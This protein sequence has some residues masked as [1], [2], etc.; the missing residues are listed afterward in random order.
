MREWR[1]AYLE[2]GVPG[3]EDVNLLLGSVDHDGDQILEV[4]LDRASLLELDETSTEGVSGKSVELQSLARLSSTRLSLRRTHKPEPEVGCDLVVPASSGVQLSSN[5]LADNLGQSSLVGG[6]D[7]LVV[8]LG[9][10]LQQPRE[11]STSATMSRDT[12]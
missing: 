8:S 5:V 3:H 10:K 2:M 12:R 4:S 1:G 11:S 9:N 7:V 6:V